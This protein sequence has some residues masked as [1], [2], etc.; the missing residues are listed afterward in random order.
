[1][2][3][4]FSFSLSQTPPFGVVGGV[5]PP[6]PQGGYPPS[7]G[8]LPPPGGWGPTPPP[9]PRGGEGGGAQGVK[10]GPKTE[11]RPGIGPFI[12]FKNGEK[13]IWRPFFPLLHESTYFCVFLRFLGFSTLCEFALFAKFA[14]FC[15]FCVFLRFL[16]FSRFAHIYWDANSSENSIT[17][18]FSQSTRFINL[19]SL[20]NRVE[21]SPVMYSGFGTPLFYQKSRR[22][23]TFIDLFFQKNT[24]SIFWSRFDFL[25][26]LRF[27][28]DYPTF[29]HRLTLFLT[30]FDLN[31]P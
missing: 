16:R 17:R 1:M 4:A 18:Q 9:P 24:V 11:N 29:C 6:S 12:F 5:P 21:M 19:F 26:K 31:C 20:P 13:W 2:T 22:F 8:V 27:L 28:A 7:G 23:I 14:F 3:S 30:N 10:N 15:V 25:I